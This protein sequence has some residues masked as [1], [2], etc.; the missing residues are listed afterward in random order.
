MSNHKKVKDYVFS[1]EKGYQFPKSKEIAKKLS[2]N[3]ADVSYIFEELKESGVLRKESKKQGVKFFFNEKY[4]D[5]E[6]E[7]K[8]RCVANKAF[9]MCRHGASHA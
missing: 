6:T 5:P 1:K 7:R 2:V 3:I 4:V 9:N 8:M